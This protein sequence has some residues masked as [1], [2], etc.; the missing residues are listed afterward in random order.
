[1]QKSTGDGKTTNSKGAEAVSQDAAAGPVETSKTTT[2][3][4]GEANA[5]DDA[6]KPEKSS[7]TKVA[8]STPKEAATTR[9][10]ALPFNLRVIQEYLKYIF[11]PDYYDPKS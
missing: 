2:T 10:S 1:M 5:A 11:G 6:A 3:K 7:A 4:G 8:S 9:E